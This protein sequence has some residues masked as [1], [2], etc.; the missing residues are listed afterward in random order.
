MLLDLPRHL[1]ASKGC[2]TTMERAKKAVMAA[3][4][5]TRAEVNTAVAERTRVGVSM[6]AAA[7]I[8][9]EAEAVVGAAAVR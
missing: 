3:A 5:R 4:V 9:V 8:P 7:N 1:A 2:S 6:A